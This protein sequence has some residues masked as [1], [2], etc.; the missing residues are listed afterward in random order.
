MSTQA[1]SSSL[2]STPIDFGNH[3]DL[4]NLKG[5]SALVTGAAR[6]I[7]LACATRLAEAGAI[8][9]ISDVRVE[10][11]QAAVRELTSKG[12]RVQFA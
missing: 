3:V 12:L 5:R 8:V 4:S 7:G 11:G 2:K 6:G 10:A 1:G 9:T